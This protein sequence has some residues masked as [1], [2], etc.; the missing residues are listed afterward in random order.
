M[1]ISAAPASRVRSVIAASEV[2]AVMFISASFVVRSSLM[3]I[4]RPASIARVLPVLEVAGMASLM[5]MSF[6]ACNNILESSPAKS[7]PSK[8]VSSGP[9]SSASTNA[10]EATSVP[11]PAS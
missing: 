3:K 1:V 4:L 9:G 11:T 8:I 5:V 6:V 2:L 10:T 7:S